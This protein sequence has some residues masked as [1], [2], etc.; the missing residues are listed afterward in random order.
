[1]TRRTAY[2]A[3]PASMLL[4]VAVLTAP[5]GASAPPPLAAPQHA[6]SGPFCVDFDLLTMD[7]QAPAQAT[8]AAGQPTNLQ[9][10]VTN[11]SPTVG[12]EK[13]TWLA[14][15]SAVLGSSSTKAFTIA[16]PASLPLGAYVAGTAATAGSCAPGMDGSGYAAS[17]PAGSG[18]GHVELNPAIPG[19]AVIKPATFGI[20]SVTTGV[21]GALTANVSVYIPDVTLLGVP[22]TTTA[23][24]TYAAATSSAGPTF[25]LDTRATLTPLPLYTASDFSMNTIALNFNGL[26]TEAAAGAVAPPVAFAR[27]SLQCTSVG[28]TLAANARGPSTVAAPFTQTIT[29]CPSAAGLVSVAPDPTNPKAITFTMK[30]PTAAVPGRTAS[31]EYV[32][33]DGAKATA[34]A[35]TTHTYSVANP[36]VALITV[37]DSAGARS[38][39][40][41][42]KIGASALRGKQVE[43][44][45]VTGSVTDQA[46]DKGLGGEDVAA[47][48]CSTR[49][50]PIAQCDE[51]GT[52]VTKAS[53][54]YRLKIPEVKKKGFVLVV[55][56]GTATT[57]A[58]TQARFGS[59]RSID[60]LPQPDVTLKVSAKQVRPGGSVR[61]SGKVEPGKKGKTV[62]L[63][64]F[65]GGKWRSIGKTTISQQGR[66]SLTYVVRAPGTK[67]KVRALVDGTAKTLQATSPVR[68]IK[69]LR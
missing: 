47:Y 29:G 52:A 21:G 8:T 3:G 4:A 30:Q 1:M 31:L 39:A 50:T 36:V 66:Y 67:V 54:S 58:S 28:S 55:H 18:S 59:K 68:K 20:T 42:V 5:A 2:V 22:L 10:R 38:A 37:V 53:G 44:N 25:T 65:I 11:S 62:R 33:G 46:T 27:Q 32:F 14:K 7:A 19:P 64:G 16:D 26:V 24:I 35:T 9:L 57:S 69:I 41:Q 15:V 12:S 43:G 17:C 13:T 6:C 49:T 63:Q 51:V 48:R 40:L 34:G 23:P 61:L 45:L 56:G 60:V